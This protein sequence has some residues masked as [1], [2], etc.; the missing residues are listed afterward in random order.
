[1][2]IQIHRF[3]KKRKAALSLNLADSIVII[4]ANQLIWE[5]G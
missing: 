3:V 4:G 5:T 2:K 1:M